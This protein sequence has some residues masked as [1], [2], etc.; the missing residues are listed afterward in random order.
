MTTLV[1]KAPCS[2]CAG[3]K[4][5]EGHAGTG[6]LIPQKRQTE[7]HTGNADNE[8]PCFPSVFPP[9]PFSFLEDS[10]QARPGQWFLPG[11]ELVLGRAC[12]GLFPAG[13]L[14]G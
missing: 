7:T 14:Q 2:S 13:M 5:T 3:S 9:A 11:T 10:S 1:G 4:E 6:V 12:P 8:R